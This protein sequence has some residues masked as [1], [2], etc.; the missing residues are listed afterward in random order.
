MVT[1]IPLYLASALGYILSAIREFKIQTMISMVLVLMS[2][3]LSC[4]YIKFYGVSG[5]IVSLFLI[6][7]LQFMLTSL[8]IYYYIFIKRK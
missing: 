1:G 7:S 4:F 3:P 6:Y 8:A 2:I 5:V